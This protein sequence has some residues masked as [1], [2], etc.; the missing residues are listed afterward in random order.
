[1][2]QSSK[3]MGGND[4]SNLFRKIPCN[5]RLPEK[6]GYYQTNRGVK[7]F[8]PHSLQWY[9]THNDNPPIEYWYEAIQLPTDEEIDEL[10]QESCKYRMNAVWPLYELG[11]RD[12]SKKSIKLLTNKK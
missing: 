12:G 9:Y 10:G 2:Y 11:F 7:H 8:S 6:V 5:E 1:M 4:M 3:S